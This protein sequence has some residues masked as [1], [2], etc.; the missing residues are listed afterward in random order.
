MGRINN[1]NKHYKP[2]GNTPRGKHVASNS[3]SKFKAK[4]LDTSDFQKAMKLAGVSKNLFSRILLFSGIKKRIFNNTKFIT[5]SSFGKKATS[6]YSRKKIAKRFGISKGDVNLGH[7]EFTQLVLKKYNDFQSKYKKAKSENLFAKNTCTEKVRKRIFLK[8]V[9]APDIKDINRRK[10]M[11]SKKNIS[12]ILPKYLIDEKHSKVFADQQAI[13]GRGAQKTATLAVNI[14]NVEEKRVTYSLQGNLYDVD[15]DFK[16]D[17]E[18]YEAVEKKVGDLAPKIKVEEWGF[19]KVFKFSER[20]DKFNSSTDGFCTKFYE[21]TLDKLLPN[22]NEKSFKEKPLGQTL[23]I[24]FSLGKAFRL[25]HMTQTEICD[26][27]PENVVYDPDT[28][29]ASVIDFGALLSYSALEEQ[30]EEIGTP[31]YMAPEVFSNDQGSPKMS[32]WSFGISMLKLH[33]QEIG[34]KIASNQKNHHARFLNEFNNAVK[35]LKEKEVDNEVEKDLIKLILDC[36]ESDPDKRPNGTEIYIK[37]AQMKI[38]FFLEDKKSANKNIEKLL[39]GMLS[40]KPEDVP[41]LIKTVF[42]TLS[43]IEQINFQLYLLDQ[44]PSHERDLLYTVLS[45]VKANDFIKQDQVLTTNK[46]FQSTR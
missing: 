28:E 38:K 42:S 14:T 15:S 44:P 17:W 45:G 19:A 18:N 3:I 11:L 21:K 39:S 46:I 26:F 2:L 8:I 37:A 23:N 25:A 41:D 35:A 9:I 27:K 6:V 1:H 36:L 13:L 24:V 40:D 7:K 16:E 5:S 29:Q 30:P 43:E 20:K 12:K 34:H 32:S 33:Y 22:Q 31:N 4:K 10:K